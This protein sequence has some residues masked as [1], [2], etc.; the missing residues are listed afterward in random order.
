[1]MSLSR[2]A[3]PL[4]TVYGWPVGFIH[5]KAVTMNHSIH[6]VYPKMDSNRISPMIVHNIAEDYPGIDPNRI[7][8][9]IVHNI[10][11]DYTDIN[12]LKERIVMVINVELKR[13]KPHRIFKNNVKRSLTINYTNLKWPPQKD[14]IIDEVI[15]EFMVQFMDQVESEH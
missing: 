10:A 5:R 12:K 7:S 2:R 4:P 1:M 6:E 14:T 3:I 15:G 13:Y 8:P 9:M 11:E